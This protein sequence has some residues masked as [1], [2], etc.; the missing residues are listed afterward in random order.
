MFVIVFVGARPSPRMIGAAVAREEVR[1]VEI[2]HELVLGAAVDEVHVDHAAERQLAL[3]A[4]VQL[5]RYGVSRSL[6]MTRP[7]RVTSSVGMFDAGAAT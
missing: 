6:L 2:A 1:G 4:G 7:V 5:L 3:D